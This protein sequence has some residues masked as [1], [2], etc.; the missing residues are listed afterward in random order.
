[1]ANLILLVVL[2]IAIV[3]LRLSAFA[4]HHFSR[5]RLERYCADRNLERFSTILALDDETVMAIYSWTWLFLA[6]GALLLVDMSLEGDIQ[7]GWLLIVGMFGLWLAFVTFDLLLARPLGELYAER[8]VYHAWPALTACRLMMWPIVVTGRLC[9]RLCRWFGGVNDETITPLHEEILTVVNEGERDGMVL[10]ENAADMIEGLIELHELAVS[11]VM[12]PRTS[13]VMLPQS[14]TIEEARQLISEKGHSRIPVF[15]ASRDDIVGIIHAKDL[16]PH[17]SDEGAKS[18]RIDSLE[19]RQ[20]A[21]VQETKQVDLL[22]REFQR[23]RLHLAIVHDEYGGVAGL[24]TIEDILEEIVGEIADEYDPA[25]IPSVHRIS[26]DVLE[27][28]ASLH[29]DEV[30][31]ILEVN[32]PEDQDF[33]TLG[34]YVLELLG[35]VPIK[36]ESVRNT[37]AVFTVLEIRRR[38]I[39]RVRV[40]RI[41]E[42]GKVKRSQ[43]TG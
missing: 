34:G 20:P 37:Q 6:G 11:E 36:G 21:Y 40:E 24:V 10:A 30:N 35:H 13:M 1:M 19:L 12:T 42:D 5:A 14:G 41:T 9:D 15:G 29:V 31:E 33:D 23:E 25:E 22:L 17:L 4:L 18:Q 16:L 39:R 7:A 27:I 3:A 8:I 28:D 26:D 2:I 38:M 43:P 32:I